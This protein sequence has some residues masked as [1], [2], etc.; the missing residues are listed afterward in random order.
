MGASR[1]I[2]LAEL[3][4]TLER[5]RNPATGAIYGKMTLRDRDRNETRFWTAFVED[6]ELIEK[7]EKLRVGDPI[8]VSGPFSAQMFRG[9]P[10]LKI[11]VYGVLDGHERRKPKP[12][13]Q[14]RREEKVESNEIDQAPHD[15]GGL[16]DP[17]PL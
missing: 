16:D 8:A 6:V 5:R 2:V 11:S 4:R 9:E 13:A 7:I 17:I 12:K 1:N 15:D 3:H 10:Q 14:I